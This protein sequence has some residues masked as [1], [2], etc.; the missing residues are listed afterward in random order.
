[1]KKPVLISLITIVT[2]II[3]TPAL[4]SKYV[5]SKTKEVFALNDKSI[6]EIDPSGKL[7][8]GE[9][10]YSLLQNAIT[11]KDVKLKYRTSPNSPFELSV[12][13]IKST[14]IND[15]GFISP[16]S[17]DVIIKITG[18]RLE[19]NLTR[20]AEPSNFE[21]YLL[22]GSNQIGFDFTMS[23]SIINNEDGYE[24]KSSLYIDRIGEIKLELIA[25]GL[26]A[27]KGEERSES[28]IKEISLSNIGLHYESENFSGLMH[29]ILPK[30]ILDTSRESL[31]KEIEIL[32]RQLES[33]INTKGFSKPV[34]DAAF[35]YFNNE[36]L[37]VSIAS[38]K[39]IKGDEL[40]VNMMVAMENPVLAMS[41]FGLTIKTNVK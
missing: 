34:S 26:L 33:N 10:S 30:H 18:G 37:S 29:S 38:S 39:V 1:M 2:I 24:T 41:A 28:I 14:P 7:S 21:T 16:F 25:N 19:A 9:I 13:E 6:K 11:V 4:V 31:R 22:S 3:V 35:A 23:N 40:M 32:T 12:S 15:N 17:N 5:E 8:Y 27:I 20:Y 36:E